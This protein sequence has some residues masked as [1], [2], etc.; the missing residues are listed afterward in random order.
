MRTLARVPQLSA[1][2]PADRWHSNPSPSSYRVQLRMAAPQN[3]Y[4]AP[5]P[6]QRSRS[7][8]RRWWRLTCGR[9]CLHAAQASSISSTSS[10]SWCLRFSSECWTL[11]LRC[12]ER[13]AQCQTVQ[14][15]VKTSQVPF[16]GGVLVAPVVVQRRLYRG[17][18]A[19]AVY[20]HRR[21]SCC[22]A[23]ANPGLGFHRCEHAATSSSSSA[24]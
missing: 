4:W 9:P 7:R 20:R 3:K 17:G 6:P 13:Y 2:C 10:T 12:R 5:C 23:D 18:A 15:T 22:G 19:V 8:S 1:D 24:N 14:E 21:H 16:L 11:Q